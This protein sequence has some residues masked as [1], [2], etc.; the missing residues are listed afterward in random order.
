MVSYR[1]TQ[2]GWP[3]LAGVVPTFVVGVFMVVRDLPFAWL[4]VGI[5]PIVLLSLGWVTVSVDDTDVVAQFGAGLIRKRV[6][7]ADIQSFEA[8]RNPW[9]VRLGHPPDSRRLALQRGGILRRGFHDARRPPHPH[10]HA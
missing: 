10:R 8:V 4:V 6:P 2:I 5:A 7:L 9:Y 3:T 1:Q